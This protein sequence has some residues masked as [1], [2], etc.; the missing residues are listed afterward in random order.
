MPK[1][2]LADDHVIIR[3]GLRIII[4]N[5]IDHSLVED[6]WDGLSVIEKVKKE[7]YELIVLD[8]NMPGT[9][10]VS[11]VKQ[12]LSLR[13]E[14]RILM[15][16]MNNEEIY[17]KKYLQI[18]AMGYLSKASPETEIRKAIES[19]LNNRKYL[20]PELL[21]CFIHDALGEKGLNPFA[22]LSKREEE[23]L[24]HILKG[25]T[26]TDISHELDVDISTIGT[27]KARILQK[28]NCKNV[29]DVNSLAGLYDFMIS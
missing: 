2:L 26:L 21:Q 19:M 29:L 25:E 18:G 13:P 1:I 11:L 20:S 16:S 22:R 28:L 15:F 24:R 5:Y 14:A 10:S 7:N 17:A 12:I 9:N 6:A 27:Y 23:I 4:E 3:S 8:V